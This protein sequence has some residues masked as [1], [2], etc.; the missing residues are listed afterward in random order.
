MFRKFG[1]FGVYRDY[2]DYFGGDVFVLEDYKSM[3]KNEYK[4]VRSGVSVF[5]PNL[6]SYKICFFSELSD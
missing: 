2:A 6:S 1:K 3:L 5:G 4:S